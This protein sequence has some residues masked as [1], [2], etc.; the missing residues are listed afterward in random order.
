MQ[1]VH[2]QGFERHVTQLDI[3]KEDGLTLPAITYK[4]YNI[5]LIDVSHWFLSAC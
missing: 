3:M 5:K 4:A 1:G 2:A